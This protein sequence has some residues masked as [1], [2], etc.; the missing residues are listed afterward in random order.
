MASDTSAGA[1]L[2]VSTTAPASFNSAGYGA[3]T[4]TTVGEIDNLGEFGRVYELITRKPLASRGTVKAKGSYDEGDLNLQLA[5]DNADAGQDLLRT[6]VNSDDPVS[7][8]VTLQGGDIYY[9]QAVVMSF[10]LNVGTSS[11]FTNAT[12]QLAIT[13]ST[14]GVGIVEA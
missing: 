6:A 8:K 14:G 5:L 2:A 10:R 12:C 9:F 3:L 4:F 13:T 7:C 11:Q 1:T